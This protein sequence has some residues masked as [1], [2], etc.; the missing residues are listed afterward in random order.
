MKFNYKDQPTL[1][2]EDIDALDISDEMKNVLKNISNI[3]ISKE[4]FD[5]L[6]EHEKMR[7]YAHGGSLFM[8]REDD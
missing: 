1:N 2:D 6:S 5:N 3:I 7:L 8:N 4:K